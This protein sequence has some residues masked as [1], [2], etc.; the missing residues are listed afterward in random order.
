MKKNMILFFITIGL[1]LFSQ[2]YPSI[3]PEL[4][5]SLSL[6]KL[7]TTPNTTSG[8]SLLRAPMD[9]QGVLHILMNDGSI[10]KFDLNFFP[11]SR[12][13]IKKRE[14]LGAF[15]LK[16][17]GLEGYFIF[18]GTYNGDY[19]TGIGYVDP[20]SESW[21]EISKDT[22]YLLTE[23]TVLV[24]YRNNSNFTEARPFSDLNKVY[25]L[26]DLLRQNQVETVLGPGWSIG[27]SGTV[28]FKGEEQPI[29][30]KKVLARLNQ[31]QKLHAAPNKLFTSWIDSQIRKREFYTWGGAYLGRDSNGN[32]FG[33]SPGPNT[34]DVI[35]ADGEVKASYRA[36]FRSVAPPEW[37][38]LKQ[39]EGIQSSGWQLNPVDGNL[40][41]LVGYYDY[42]GRRWVGN[43]L[44]LYKAPR[45]W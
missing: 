25:Q 2:D 21:I 19:G 29:N 32:Y 15:N 4:V 33:T 41:N 1:P 26:S 14:S 3:K 31:D 27:P 7:N 18:T 17:V 10:R 24:R 28:F 38:A 43:K 40:Y 36:D 8:S 34:Y 6:E 39:E 9:S 23:N 13:L 30:I 5:S 11:L 37:L 42:R 45:E 22:D 44:Y 12:V 35:S 20:K 16:V